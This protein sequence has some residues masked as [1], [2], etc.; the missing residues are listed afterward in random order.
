MNLWTSGQSVKNVELT[1]EAH[2]IPTLATPS[3][4]LLC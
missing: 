2:S 1:W 3:Y 4:A